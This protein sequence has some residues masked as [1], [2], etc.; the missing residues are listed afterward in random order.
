MNCALNGVG[1]GVAERT[2]TGNESEPYIT[3]GARL[4]GKPQSS[5]GA[6]V[7][8]LHPTQIMKALILN[9]SGTIRLSVCFLAAALL[10]AL[11]LRAQSLPCV[12]T[13]T[14]KFIMP[15]Q[16]NGGLDVRDSRPL[17]SGQLPGTSSN[18]LADDFFC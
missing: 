5:T 17:N 8:P 2:K 6:F 12:E 3:R 1:S 15:P 11:D 4:E 9:L 13:N 10:P 18:I 16:V 7:R 14:V